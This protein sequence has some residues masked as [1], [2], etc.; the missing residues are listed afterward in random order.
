MRR[1]KKVQPH[2]NFNKIQR[3]FKW[4]AEKRKRETPRIYT[5]ATNLYG[6]FFFFYFSVWL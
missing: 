5:H 2:W 1:K 6:D 4:W 3:C